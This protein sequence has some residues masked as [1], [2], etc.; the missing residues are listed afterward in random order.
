[1]KLITR[2]RGAILE[3][4]E[5]YLQYLSTFMRDDIDNV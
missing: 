1:M 4:P 3:C 2:L 5:Y